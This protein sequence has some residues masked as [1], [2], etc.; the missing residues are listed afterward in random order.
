[1]PTD[2]NQKIQ[3]RSAN[4]GCLLANRLSIVLVLLNEMITFGCIFLHYHAFYTNLFIRDHPLHKISEPNK[5]NSCL[6]QV[7]HTQVHLLHLSSCLFFRKVSQREYLMDTKTLLLTHP[8]FDLIHYYL[9]Y[10]PAIHLTQLPQ[11]ANTS[12]ILTFLLVSLSIINWDN[13]HFFH[14]SGTLLFD[15]VCYIIS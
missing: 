14:S 4:I 2:H 12:I 9:N 7:H 11:L 8:L 3:V 10:Y 6:L 15:N 13:A 1:M 5:V